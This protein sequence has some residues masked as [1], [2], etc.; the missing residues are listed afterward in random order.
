MSVFEVG[1]VFE[2]VAEEAV[3]GYVSRPD[4]SDSFDEVPTLE[5]AGQKKN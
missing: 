2:A 5:V 1:G 4:K 3:A